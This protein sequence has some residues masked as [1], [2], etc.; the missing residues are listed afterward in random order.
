MH[1]NRRTDGNRTR[2]SVSASTRRWRTAIPATRRPTARH[3]RSLSPRSPQRKYCRP[4]QRIGDRS[5]APSN[6]PVIMVAVLPGPFGE[7]T[8]RLERRFLT[9]ALI[10]TIVFV[11]LTSAVILLAFDAFGRAG[12]AWSSLPVSLQLLLTL[13]STALVWFL[14]S[15]IASNWRKIVRLYEGYPFARFYRK[16][17]QK[18]GI[19]LFSYV[20]RVPGASYHLHEQR[21]ASSR[22]AYRRYPPPEFEQEVLP[23]SLG[24]ILLAAERYGLDRYGVDV[25]LLWPRLYWQLPPE[26]RT[27]LEAFK[28]EHQLPIALSFMAAWSTLIGSAAVLVAESSWQLLLV[29]STVG[30]SLSLG[31]YLLALERAEEYGEQ[32]RTVV[33]LYHGSLKKVWSQPDADEEEF[34]QRV[35]FFVEHGVYLSTTNQQLPPTIQPDPPPN[36]HKL[37]APKGWGWTLLR[38]MRLSAIVCLVSACLIA[39]GALWLRLQEVGVVVVKTQTEQFT[40]PTKVRIAY[41]PP[42]QVP[43]GSFSH[44]KAVDGRIS[45][46]PLPS[47]TPITALNSLASIPAAAFDSIID[48]PVFPAGPVPND[49]NVGDLVTLGFKR[50]GSTINDVRLLALSQP[51]TDDEPAKVTVAFPAQISAFRR[52]VGSPVA[53]IRS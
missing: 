42:R 8:S 24:N 23:T 37:P 3:G 39:T 33:D 35:Q 22:T 26:M 43:P 1:G 44:I 27:D 15:L 51:R 31:A 46:E 36:L 41:L 25:T 34:F 32:I 18:K 13:A 9:T 4:D 29:V 38:R 17:A 20:Q 2:L 14:S 53:I 11:V 49:V 10:P 50:C 48:L 19:D 52:C 21:H 12:D 40:F 45:L 6:H 28:E 7:A 47:G 16:R 30:L 5:D